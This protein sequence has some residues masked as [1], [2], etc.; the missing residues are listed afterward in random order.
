MKS[1]DPHDFSPSDDNSI[2]EIQNPKTTV[3]K[4]EQ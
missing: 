1:N 3:L 4:T 2:E